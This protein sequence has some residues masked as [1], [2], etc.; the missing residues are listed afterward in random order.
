MTA[1]TLIAVP[2]KDP[3]VAK[4][5]LASDLNKPARGRLARVLLRRTLVFLAP[6]IRAGW[7]LAV[8]TSSPDVARVAQNMGVYVIREQ[9]AAGLNSAADQA[10]NWA[11]RAGYQRLALI[12]SDLIGP[13][14]DDLAQ[15]LAS[16]AEVTICPAHDGGT[17]ALVVKL[18]Y[19]AGL[20][21]G[22]NSAQLHYDAAKAAGLTSTF[23][24]AKSFQYD[25]DT[26]AQL[27]PAI[28]DYPDLARAVRG[29]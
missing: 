2:V 18:P 8:V 14:S 17:N 9:R 20:F 21:Y 23:C 11:G 12:P 24:F 25:L 22:P 28:R 3:S 1:H 27:G 13:A 5:R 26:A 19:S 6:G 16:R 29:I 15:L 10:I 4:V 7:D